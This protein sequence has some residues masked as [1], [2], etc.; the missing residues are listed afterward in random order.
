MSTRRFLLAPLLALASACGASA[1]PATTTTPEPTR[2]PRVLRAD[3]TAPGFPSLETRLRDESLLIV[4][5]GRRILL[6]DDGVRSASV[7]FASPI[8]GIAEREDGYLFLTADGVGYRVEGSDALGRPVEAF[9]T[10]VRRLSPLGASRGRLVV[11][12]GDLVGDLYVSDGG[13]LVKASLPPRSVL[14]AT[15][16]DDARGCVLLFDGTGRFTSDGGETYRVVAGLDH[17]HSLDLHGGSCRFHVG[18][19]DEPRYQT[20]DERGFAV[21]YE[22]GEEPDR[23]AVY[24][25][26]P[27]ELYLSRGSMARI[28]RNRAIAIGPAP[29]T[30]QVFALDDGR[31]L[32]THEEALPEGCT[33]VD[34]G[35]RAVAICS[36]E[37]GD[38]TAWVTSDGESFEPLGGLARVLSARGTQLFGSDDG[39]LAFTGPCEDDPSI[40]STDDTVCV[41]RDLGTGA[42]VSMMISEHGRSAIRDL[43]GD[44]ILLETISSNRYWLAQLGTDETWELAVEGSRRI[45]EAELAS[46]GTLVVLA[47]HEGAVRA[48]HVGPPRGELVR[49]ELPAGAVDASFQDALHGVAAGRSMQEVFRTRDGGQ[50]WAPMRILLEG[51]ASRTPLLDPERYLECHRNYCLGYSWRGGRGRSVVVRPMDES[52]EPTTLASQGPDR[53]GEEPV[54]AL[55]IPSLL[56]CEYV[57]GTTALE[58]PVPAPART[59][60]TR[61][62]GDGR[63]TAWVDEVARGRRRFTQIHWTGEDAE[64]RYQ[65][66][67]RLADSNAAAGTTVRMDVIS[68]ARAGAL[69]NVCMLQGETRECQFAMALPGSVPIMLDGTEPHIATHGM[70][71]AAYTVRDLFFVVVPRA[72]GPMVF[73][74]DP[75]S[76]GASSF[77]VGEAIGETWVGIA[78]SSLGP[79]FV[80]TDASARVWHAMVEQSGGLAFPPFAAITDSRLPVCRDDAAS[81]TVRWPARVRLRI[82]EENIDGGASAEIS[83]TD[84]PACVRRFVMESDPSFAI[85]TSTPEGRL[86]GFVDR[87]AEGLRNIRCSLR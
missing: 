51:D 52:A 25:Y 5:G 8:V 6:G 27:A 20:L 39:Q 65:L 54:S 63:Y 12:A 66:S 10:N 71:T 68:A 61:V 35:E 3:V 28:G 46:D 36:P 45:L 59:A 75:T 19:P 40:A 64:G 31:L 50:T 76:G 11:L 48:V 26:R 42:H 7:D 47:E 74:F 43:A 60:A 33:L 30:V 9:R 34:V 21:D 62:Y 72:T 15:F 23:D 73:I 44:T 32:S 82:G 84:G 2:R 49:R 80:V 29:T 18:T 86:E 83:L 13:D 79:Y 56:R 37:E 58:R 87:G 38:A 70:M 14:G 4:R 16:T 78:E 85:L 55:S 77:D 81:A 67:S 17:A 1:P 24:P 69:L 41:L 53:L 22:P 57:E